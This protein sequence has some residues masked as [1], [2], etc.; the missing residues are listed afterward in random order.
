MGAQ[1]YPGLTCP[2]APLPPL[3]T[4]RRE[5]TRKNHVIPHIILRMAGRR[6]GLGGCW[7]A[8]GGS[9]RHLHGWMEAEQEC[10]RCWGR[11]IP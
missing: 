5:A 3:V 8:W 11:A 6:A 10:D 2:S 1:S 4:S 7:E 9:L